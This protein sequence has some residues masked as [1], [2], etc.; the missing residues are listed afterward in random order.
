MTKTKKPQDVMARIVYKSLNLP[1]PYDDTELAAGKIA[2]T[3]STR[4]RSSKRGTD[5]PSTLAKIVRRVAGIPD[6]Y[7]Q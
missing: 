6:H 2:K 3:S 1:Y 7:N 4:R 5:R